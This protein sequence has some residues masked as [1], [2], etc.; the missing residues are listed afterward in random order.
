MQT[1]PD[2]LV[3]NIPLGSSVRR[4]SKTKDETMR[5]TVVGAGYVGLTTGVCLSELGHDVICADIDRARIA[6]LREGVLPFKE[7]GLETLASQN[8]SRG[9]L[10]FTSDLAAAAAGRDILLIAVGTPKG[11]DGEAD[12]SFVRQAA[13]SIAPVMAPKTVVTLKSTVVVGTAREVREIIAEERGGLDFWV[14]SNPEF[15]R[16]GSAVKDFL[17]PD[18]IVIGADDREAGDRLLELYKPLLDKGIPCVETGTANAELI[19]YAAN[20]FLA[21]KI[22]F[23]NDVA[24]LCENIEGDISAV[25]KGI[26][27]DRRIGPSFLMPGP[28]YGGSCFPKDTAAFAQTGRLFSAPQ[29]LID[30]LIARNDLRKQRIAAR[31]VEALSGVAKPIVAVLGVAF[32]ANTDDVRDSAALHI[33]PAL[34]RAGIIVRAYDPWAHAGASDVLATVVWA[35]NLYA[36]ARGADLLLVLTEWDLFRSMDLGKLKSAMRGRAI[37]DCRNLLDQTAVVRHGFA[38]TSVGRPPV[39]RIRRPSATFRRLPSSEGKESNADGS[40]GS[41]SRS[42]ATRR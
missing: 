39:P 22:G 6:R 34:Q 32:K 16:E 17:S 28:G 42:G 29:P 5:V 41:R 23:I 18:R 9:R 20:A 8:I 30:T 2:L 25:A 15:L 38:Y 4:G 3:R 12:L 7:E 40:H 36:A 13:R 33:I 35:E 26:G 19:K 1:K 11:A 37:F 21:L 14:T 10:R 31:V 27:L 24:D